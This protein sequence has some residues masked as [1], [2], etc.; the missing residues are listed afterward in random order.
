[1]QINVQ[2]VQMVLDLFPIT[3]AILAQ[4]IIVS[5]VPPTQI[6]ARDA[7]MDME[8]TELAA[9]NAL[10]RSALI[11]L[12]TRTFAQL[13]LLVS[14]SMEQAVQLVNIHSAKCVLSTKAFVQ[15]VKQV[16]VS[17]EAHVHLVQT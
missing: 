5:I 9:L 13:V 15:S 2:L 7:E 1:M 4:I 8:S 6:H 16:S 3:D 14:E 17:M 11:A 12:S 10:T